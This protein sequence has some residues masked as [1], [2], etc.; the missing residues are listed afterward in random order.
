MEKGNGSLVDGSGAAGGQGNRGEQS[1][2]R[3]A[4]KNRRRGKSLRIGVAQRRERKREY[5]FG[6]WQK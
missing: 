2:L 6:M 3:R 4:K 1:F 5:C